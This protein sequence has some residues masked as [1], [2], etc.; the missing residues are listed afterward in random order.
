VF[1]WNCRVC[2]LEYSAND[3]EEL[4]WGADERS[5][6]YSFCNC[7]GVEFGYQDCLP[8]A[9]RQFRSQWLERGA[10]WDDKARMPKDWNLEAQL[11]AVPT[12]YQ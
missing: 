11:A 6:D 2:G 4:P 1:T 9:A 12:A 5:P 10:P 7:C 8:V 3:P